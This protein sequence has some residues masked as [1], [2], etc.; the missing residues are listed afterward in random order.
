MDTSPKIKSKIK[1][2]N[3]NQNRKLDKFTNQ[4]ISKIQIILKILTTM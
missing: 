4:M 2:E 3:K 1:I